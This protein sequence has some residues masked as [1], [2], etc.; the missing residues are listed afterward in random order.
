MAGGQNNAQMSIT[1]NANQAINKANEVGNRLKNVGAEGMSAS[2]N[3]KKGMKEGEVAL[4][5]VSTKANATRQAITSVGSAGMMA[6]GQVQ[7]G[8]QQATTSLNAANVAAQG[9]ARSFGAVGMSAFGTAMSVGM[10]YTSLTNYGKASLKLEKALTG[11]KSAEN[12]LLYYEEY[13]ED[14]RK[15]GKTDTVIYAHYTRQLTV[16]REK[17]TNQEKK[18]ALAQENVNDVNIQMAL[19]LSMVTLMAGSTIAQLTGLTAAQMKNAIASK[20]NI[21]AI[22]G[23]GTALKAL[24]VNPIFLV[25]TAAFLIWE[26]ALSSV[27]ENMFGLEK[28]TLSVFK[29]IEKLMGGMQQGEAVL[30]DYSAEAQ[31]AR[32]ENEMLAE[33]SNHV[34]DSMNITTDSVKNSTTALKNYNAMIKQAT[35]NS[36]G[37]FNAQKKTKNIDG[38]NYS[39]RDYLKLM[40]GYKSGSHGGTSEQVAAMNKRARMSANMRAH[41][42]KLKITLAKKDAL[43]NALRGAGLGYGAINQETGDLNLDRRRLGIRGHKMYGTNYTEMGYIPMGQ[44]IDSSNIGAA[45][46]AWST[47]ASR[48]KKQVDW[49]KNKSGGKYGGYGKYG[50]LAKT[51]KSFREDYLQELKDIVA[52]QVAASLQDQKEL[53]AEKKRLQDLNGKQAQSYYDTVGT[54]QG[55]TIHDE[56]NYKSYKQRMSD[57]GTVNT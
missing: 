24:A 23:V 6:G 20:I 43:T 49:H 27:I 33:S 21:V 12:N 36:T 18:V 30:D 10:A 28:G 44:S 34:A 1:L 55:F 14:M 19:S 9:T 40:S 52:A 13:L 51:L 35:A 47:Y 3:I 45:K 17:Y 50:S 56:I 57:G 2:N 41:K 16:L 8:M 7:S 15:R 22:K 39:A 25:A 29:Q 53:D 4:A 26:L 38:V 46:G 31:V 48:V 42:A 11:L 32:I 37:F 54:H 5:A